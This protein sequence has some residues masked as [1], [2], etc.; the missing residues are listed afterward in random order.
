M[1]MKDDNQ[2][3]DVV[4]GR[5]LRAVRMK[6]G[7]SQDRVGELLGTSF[8]QVQKYEK[9]VNRIAAST[10]WRLVHAL[11]V[12]FSEFYEG[13]EAPTPEAPKAI[14]ADAAGLLRDY[15]ALDSTGKVAVRRVVNALR[16]AS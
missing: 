1:S 2:P 10:I 12:S 5:N 16:Y 14:P 6:C 9:G 4:I 13:I 11:N 3:I 8:Q 7:L 15:V